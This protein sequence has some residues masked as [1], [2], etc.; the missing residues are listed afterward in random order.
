[1]FCVLSICSAMS[2]CC[3]YHFS[4]ANLKLLKT[5]SP[6]PCYSC[7]YA[8][9]QV[10]C[11]FVPANMHMVGISCQ[12]KCISYIVSRFCFVS[13]CTTFLSV[14]CREW[15]LSVCV[16]R[17]IDVCLGAYC[18]KCCKFIRV[19]SCMQPFTLAGMDNAGSLPRTW[20]AMCLVHRFV[21]ELWHL[22]IGKRCT[23]A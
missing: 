16:L 19:G 18:E 8:G 1:M 21:M 7:A 10:S 23:T 22:P 12:F 14:L 15:H 2:V 4:L 6:C 5:S 20:L 9:W 17:S 11:T 3:C 13:I